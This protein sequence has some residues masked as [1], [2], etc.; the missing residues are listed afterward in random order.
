MQNREAL[1]KLMVDTALGTIE[2]PK[3]TK[4]SAN[5]TITNEINKLLGLDGK[6]RISRRELRDNGK[7]AFSVIEEA[8]DVIIARRIENWEDWA[9]IRYVNYG[10]SQEFR[11][12][13]PDLFEVGMVSEGNRDMRAQRLADG[14]LVIE[15]HRYGL[16]I[17]E[18][19]ARILS[20][21]VD[22]D[23]FVDR[24]TMSIERFIGEM[25]FESLF[26]YANEVATPLRQTS[27][28]FDEEVF[29]D[30]NDRLAAIYGEAPEVYGT[31]QAL[32]K[33]T[34]VNT[35]DARIDQKET[36]G[37]YGNKAGYNLNRIPQFVRQNQLDFPYILPTDTL[38]SIVPGDEKLIKLVYEGDFMIE[39]SDEKAAR[40][41]QRVEYDVTFSFG[42]GILP[43]QYI[44]V[45]KIN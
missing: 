9:D 28:G 26:K 13:D 35:S 40:N 32:R 2:D 3:F 37:Y 43:S 29:A 16:K 38:I 30:I 20:G 1:V 7:A 10:D 45:Y 4:N 41:D 21:R 14:K 33:V 8:L 24:V 31:I 44:G 34:D 5:K 12:Y 6:R 22:W 15:T 18:E 23:K 19:L 27:T 39:P 42:I 36:I 25:V 17:Y 11:V